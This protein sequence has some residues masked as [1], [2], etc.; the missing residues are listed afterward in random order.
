[1]L[2][3]PPRMRNCVKKKRGAAPKHARLAIIRE[4]PSAVEA[5]A[6]RRIRRPETVARRQGRIDAVTDL[7]RRHS[8]RRIAF[9][10][11]MK[12]RALRA[13]RLVVRCR[14]ARRDRSERQGKNRGQRGDAGRDR[15]ALQDSSRDKFWH[16]VRNLLRKRSSVSQASKI[17][18]DAQR[19][20]L[21][22]DT[23]RRIGALGV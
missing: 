2:R 11:R 20:V 15:S 19:A 18:N 16:V 23:L 17:I 9:T 3:R 4:R 21:A 1:M 5:T 8:G 10:D 12:R 6:A 7:P 14:S 22:P 13:R